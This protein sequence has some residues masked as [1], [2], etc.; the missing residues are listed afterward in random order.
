MN[1]KKPRPDLQENPSDGLDPFAP[2]HAPS[3]VD[4]TPPAQL[5]I[6][7]RRARALDDRAA[8]R[9]RR[10]GGASPARRR[11]TNAGDVALNSLRL[12]GGG[13]AR[14]SGLRHM[15]EGE[16]GGRRAAGRT[17]DL[18]VFATS[19]C[20]ASLGNRLFYR[21]RGGGPGVPQRDRHSSPHPEPT[22]RKGF[23][24]EASTFG[25]CGSAPLC[26][27]KAVIYL[28]ALAS[29][30]LTQNWLVHAEPNSVS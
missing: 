10:A 21:F 4:E 6:T 26:V 29:T 25:R 22:I 27:P 15:A 17:S 13:S 19:E 24:P 9:K 20:W 8:Q 1:V 11:R 5:T 2:T 16:L 12:V 3:H 23:G 30:N 18:V 28:F 7:R 14:E